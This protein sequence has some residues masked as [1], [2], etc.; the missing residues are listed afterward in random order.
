[1]LL[2]KLADLRSKKEKSEK[3]DSVI[4]FAGLNRTNECTNA[5]MREMHNMSLKDFP[6]LSTRQRRQIS[7]L[8][9]TDVR[10]VLG[11]EDLYIAT[12]TGVTI[13]RKNGQTSTISG[14]LNN[15][16]KTLVKMGDYICIFPDKVFFTASGDTALWE[17]ESKYTSNA[18]TFSLADNKGQAI[19]YHNAAYY[20][21]HDPQNGDYLLTEVD[22][23]SEL[24]QYSSTSG[25]WTIITTAYIMITATNIGNYI[26][27]NDG[28]KISLDL[29][30]NTWSE[31][32]NVLPNEENGV[33]YA[34]YPVKDATTNAI[35]IGGLLSATKALTSVTFKVERLVP[36]MAF[37]T[38]AMNRLW[39]CNADGTEIYA[40]K[41]GDPTNWNCFEGISTDSW[42]VTI[43][44]EGKFTGAITYLGYPTFFKEHSLIKIA[45]S[46]SG[47]HQTKETMCRGVQDGCG[48]SL[49]IVNEILFYKSQTE[50]VAY[51]G[52]L[53]QTISKKL[54]DLSTFEKCIGGRN[55]DS[56]YIVGAY[57]VNGAYEYHMYVYNAIK[58]VW[59]EDDS[60]QYNYMATW[61]N[62]CVGIANDVVHLFDKG[63]A[64]TTTEEGNFYWSFESDKMDY[65]TANAKYIHKIVIKA[66][67]H[68]KSKARAWISYDDNPHKMLFEMR[69]EGTKVYPLTIIPR[70]CDHFSLKIDGYGDVVIYQINKVFET[71]S[72]VY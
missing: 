36:D 64:I 70:R 50:I 62:V 27:K 65:F 32:D 56:Y 43:G 42:A 26:G 23:K 72:D 33:H 28:V 14:T 31:V 29:G 16:N 10:G 61:N 9:L 1:M 68:A 39:G 4:Q 3:T 21:D 66:N 8:S 53:P 7:S 18:V 12:K 44:S 25:T 60:T 46:S 63:N 45:I 37:V 2:P 49:C 47:A 51:D 34:T 57:Y 69:T 17:M 59:V 30:S 19:T 20:E 11:G 58:S 67:M 5:E 41:L 15:K 35:T 6:H 52:S 40:S 22:G 38:E 13:I 48:K 55:K 54:G 71:G 24:Q